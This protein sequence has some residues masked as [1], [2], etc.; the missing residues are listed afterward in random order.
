MLFHKIQL[1]VSALE[2]GHLQVVHEILSKQLYYIYYVLCIVGRWEV[3][4]HEVTY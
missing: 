3:S 2:S 1:H 4:G